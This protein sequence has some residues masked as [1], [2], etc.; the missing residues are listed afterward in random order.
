MLFDSAS[1]DPEIIT[2][3][4]IPMFFLTLSPINL[5]PLAVRKIRDSRVTEKQIPEICWAVNYVVSN[6]A[7]AF[8]DINVP[9]DSSNDV[10]R[11]KVKGVRELNNE[12][13][14]RCPSCGQL[15]R[16]DFCTECGTKK[17]AA[18]AEETQNVD[19]GH[20]GQRT[21]P[22]QWKCPA[23]ETLNSGDFCIVCGKKRPM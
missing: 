3:T 6:A 9:P 12:N 7:R 8:G 20:Y 16:D 13:F 19:Q 5:I 15:N 1:F 18:Q 2:G 22:A 10:G 23:C 4:V 17:P 14:W 11:Q 21:A